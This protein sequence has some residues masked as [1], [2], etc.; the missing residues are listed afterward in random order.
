MADTG[1]RWSGETISL[2]YA[3]TTMV[4][5]TARHA[6]HADIVRELLDGTIGAFREQPYA[7][8]SATE[9]WRD[10]LARMQSSG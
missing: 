7:D 9:F 3:L 6:G 4:G 10:Y 5:E 8:G 2:G 1:T